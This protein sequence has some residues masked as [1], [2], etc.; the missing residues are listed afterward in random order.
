MTRSSEGYV[1]VFPLRLFLQRDPLEEA[2]LRD[3][4]KAPPSFF[5]SYSV[6]YPFVCVHFEK[7]R[8][9]ILRLYSRDSFVELER[10]VRTNALRSRSKPLR[11]A[12]LRKG[13][14][15]CTRGSIT[16]I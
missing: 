8:L 10:A 1:K 12:T 3:I 13:G 16:Y 14:G 4:G 5:A 9:S 2:L 6:G 15:K 11:R 7:V